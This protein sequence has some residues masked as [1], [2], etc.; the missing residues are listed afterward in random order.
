MT[1][2]KL[3]SPER[4]SFVYKIWNEIYE[5]SVLVANDIH[6]NGSSNL[7]YHEIRD[8][9]FLSLVNENELLLPNEKEYCKGKYAYDFE[10]KNATSRTGEPRKCMKCN[11]TRYSVRFCENCI[12]LYLQSLFDNW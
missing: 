9:T 3:S 7:S 8:K 11:D 6:N 4:A 1:I 12:S 2:V 10:L 5:K